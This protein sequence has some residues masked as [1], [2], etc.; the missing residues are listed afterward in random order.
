[1]ILLYTIAP[2]ISIYTFAKISALI[3]CSMYIAR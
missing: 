1:M 3:L 2:Y